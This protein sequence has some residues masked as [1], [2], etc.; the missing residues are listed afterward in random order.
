MAVRL[1]TLRT[2]RTLLPRNIT[3]FCFWYS[4]M[5]EAEWTPGPSADV[6]KR[7]YCVLCNR[8]FSIANGVITT[9]E[10]ILAQKAINELKGVWRRL[11]IYTTFSGTAANTS[12]TF[13]GFLHSLRQGARMVPQD[14]AMAISFYVLSNTFTKVLSFSAVWLQFL[15]SSLNESNINIMHRLQLYNRKPII[16]GHIFCNNLHNC[17]RLNSPSFRRKLNTFT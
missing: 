8:E 16:S 17:M 11:Q 1:S 15:I 5:S 12:K 4:F 10:T 6:R 14:E 7:A 9:A 13:R 2:G 3:F